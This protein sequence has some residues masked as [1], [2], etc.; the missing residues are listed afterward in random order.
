MAKKWETNHKTFKCTYPSLA[1][2]PRGWVWMRTCHEYIEG[3][4]EGFVSLASKFYKTKAEA[5]KHK[6]KRR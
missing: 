1:K 5:Q 4:W 3:R 6:P 2:T